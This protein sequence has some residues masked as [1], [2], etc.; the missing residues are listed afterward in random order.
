MYVEVRDNGEIILDSI[1]HALLRGLEKCGLVAEG[2]AKK[3]CPVDTGNLRNSITHKIEL[4]DG[5]GSAYIGTNIEYAPY[6]ELGTGIHA[7]GGGGRPTPWAYQDGKD[8]CERLPDSSNRCGRK[9]N[10]ETIAVSRFLVLERVKGIEPS[11]SAWEADILPLNYTRICLTK[12][13]I[14][15]G[16]GKSKEK[17]FLIWT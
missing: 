5:S 1:S 8:I 16:W 12:A 13:I 2:Y 10:R 3:L 4:N 6:V 9:K 14:N 7:E 11:C 17:L 15:D